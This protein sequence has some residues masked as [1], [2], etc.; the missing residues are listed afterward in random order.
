MDTLLVFILFLCPLIFF[1]ELGHMLFAKL[2]HVKVETFSIGFGKKIL[3]KVIGET[4]Y[5]LSIIPLGGYVKMYGDDPFK[6]RNTDDPMYDR[7]Y[8]SKKF[9]QKFLIVLGGPLA[10][11]IMAF[12]L[13]TYLPL[14]G[15]LTNVYTL[16]D[17]SESIMLKKM[18]LESGDEILSVQGKSV[19]GVEDLAILRGE[20]GK[21]EVQRN[22]KIINLEIK[23]GFMD[24]INEISKGMPLLSSRVVDKNGE[25]FFLKF[26]NDKNKYFYQKF[27]DESRIKDISVDVTNLEGVV[28]ATID[29]KSGNWNESLRRANYFPYSLVVGDV[30]EGSPA[31][32][33]G[34][35]KGDV[36]Y[37]LMGKPIYSFLQMRNEL[38]Q[39][40]N[41]D[42]DIT[43]LRNGVEKIFKLKPEERKVGNESLLT[44]GVISS[45]DR[46]SPRQRIVKIN[47]L[48]N[49]IKDGFLRMIVNS[50]KTWDGFVAI[51]SMSNAIE[52]IGGPIKIA[53]VAKASIVIS[54][55]HF[56]RLMALIS[57]NLAI[58]NLMPVPVL[59]GGHIVFILLEEIRGK[60]LPLKVLEW[61]YRVGFALIM[62]LVFIALYNDL[63]R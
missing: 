39:Y 15:E 62:S 24:F 61:S 55:D 51:F 20:I 37:R 31:R 3:K 50:K 43:V 58:L 10:N 13:Y 42:I 4:E 5:T 47:G 44:I 54:I 57:I 19:L 30:V 12:V 6:T 16:D 53:Q 8:V 25:S 9:W 27:E 48:F 11:L 38:Q 18:G 60:Q 21:V 2:F 41:V 23:L 33:S 45:M 46:V 36:L 56:L 52:M 35:G 22:E 63:F 40:K 7:T 29:I 14:K 17:I 28:K 1:H 34:I 26:K 59:D 49:A 32:F